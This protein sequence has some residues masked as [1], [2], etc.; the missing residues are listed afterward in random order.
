MFKKFCKQ[1]NRRLEFPSFGN[2]D[3]VVE[4]EEENGVKLIFCLTFAFLEARLLHK[5]CA[6]NAFFFPF[7]SNFFTYH[8]IVKFC[9]L[10]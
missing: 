6:K 10:D 3:V 5:G 2:D 8:T 4:E 9:T 7:A 1:K